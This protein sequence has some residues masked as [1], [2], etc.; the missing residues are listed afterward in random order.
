MLADNNSE[1]TVHDIEQSDNEKLPVIYKY[2]AFG[3][4][5]QTI[6]ISPLYGLSIWYSITSEML[7]LTL[8]FADLSAL[9]IGAM[10]LCSLFRLTESI[11]LNEEEIIRKTPFNETHILWSEI[12]HVE[13]YNSWLERNCYRIESTRGKYITLS[14]MLGGYDK[15]YKNLKIVVPSNKFA[16]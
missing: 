2:A 11:I 9:F 3:I 5:A 7:T 16:R 8:I 4:W 14:E 12:S 6:M 10:N 15:L 13:I 1:F